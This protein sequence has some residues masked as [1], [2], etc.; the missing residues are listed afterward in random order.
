MIEAQFLVLAGDPA[1]GDDDL[2]VRVI[3]ALYE[4][5]ICRIGRHEHEN[6]SN[7]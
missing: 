6:M 4:T 1:D 7:T 3:Y 5:Q 2:V